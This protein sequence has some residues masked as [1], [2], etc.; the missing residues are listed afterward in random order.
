[1]VG[2]HDQAASVQIDIL[3]TKS[4]QFSASHP[5]VGGYNNQCPKVRVAGIEK[6]L[7]LVGFQVSIAHSRFTQPLDVPERVIGSVTPSPGPLHHAAEPGMVSVYRRRLQARAPQVG[8][9]PLDGSRIEVIDPHLAEVFLNPSQSP[10]FFPP[11]T[12]ISGFQVLLNIDTDEGIQ[13][14]TPAT[15]VQG[16]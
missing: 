10:Q 11:G 4:H 9:E 3:P 12:R 2:P 6:H 7:E 14:D 16:I 5:G 8:Q 1:M 13:P 15:V